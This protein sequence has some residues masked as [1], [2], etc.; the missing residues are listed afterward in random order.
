MET[1]CFFCGMWAEAEETIDDTKIKDKCSS[2]GYMFDHL[3]IIIIDISAL[4]LL[5]RYEG[6]LKRIYQSEAARTVKPCWYFVTCF[7]ALSELLSKYKFYI[8]SGY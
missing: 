8:Y 1:D 2:W 6:N 5:P 3:N 4:H 7:K